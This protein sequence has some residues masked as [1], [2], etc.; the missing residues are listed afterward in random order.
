[1][2]ANSGAACSRLASA[3]V[4]R[5]AA[6]RAPRGQSGAATPKRRVKAAGVVISMVPRGGRDGEAAVG[7]R[8]LAAGESLHEGAMPL[9][10]IG[11]RDNAGN[12][13]GAVGVFLKFRVPE[14]FRIVVLAGE[15]ADIRR[16]GVARK[17]ERE[18][19]PSRLSRPAALPS[20]SK[21]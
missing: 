18:A 15:E 12:A 19:R 8:R 3:T 6:S 1:M 21:S 2:P 16:R 17:G 5:M 7:A 13:R 11:D 4:K 14:I 10:L 20:R 9:G